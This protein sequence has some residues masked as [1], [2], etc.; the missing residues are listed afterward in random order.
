[1]EVLKQARVTMDTMAADRM[2]TPCIKQA[3]QM[4][5]NIIIRTVYRGISCN[6]RGKDIR[7]T[8][9]EGCSHTY[10]RHGSASPVGGE[11]IRK[12]LR[13]AY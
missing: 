5:A 3:M 6:F 2:P 7:A 12:Q 13:A 8:G 10:G 11:E 9:R 1:M 4:S